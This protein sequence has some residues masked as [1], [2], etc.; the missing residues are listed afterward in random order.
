M[1]TWFANARRRLKKENKMTWVPKNRSSD[2]TN[3]GSKK[4]DDEDDDDVTS[5]LSQENGKF[6]SILITFIVLVKLIL[7]LLVFVHVGVPF[8]KLPRYFP[9]LNHLVIM[10]A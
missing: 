2:S 8:L 7:F 9:F 6:K 4:T 5:H 10:S 3:P 1:S